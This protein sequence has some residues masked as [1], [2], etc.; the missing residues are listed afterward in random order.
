[1]TAQICVSGSYKDAKLIDFSTAPFPQQNQV[2]QMPDNSKRDTS[3]R[4]PAEQE[5]LRT[6]NADPSALAKLLDEWM[7][8]DATEQRETFEALRRSLYEHRPGG[9]KIFS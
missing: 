4:P 5:V 7:H 3:L 6:R 8:G 1:V 9:Y 2:E